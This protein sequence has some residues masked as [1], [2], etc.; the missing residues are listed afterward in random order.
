MRTE[1]YRRTIC[2]LSVHGNG[3]HDRQRAIDARIDV[4]GKQGISVKVSFQ[5]HFPR[6]FRFQ[7]KMHSM[8]ID[9]FNHIIRNLTKTN[10]LPLL[11]TLNGPDD[12][13]LKVKVMDVVR[14]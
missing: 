1:R 3:V 4:D 6:T 14:A 8:F 12:F 11:S 13:C 7:Y 10:I 2:S 9:C 5:F